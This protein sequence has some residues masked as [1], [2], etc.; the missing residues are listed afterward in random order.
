MCPST[1]NVISRPRKNGST[2]TI[3]STTIIRAQPIIGTGLVV[4]ARTLVIMAVTKSTSSRSSKS[5]NETADE[6]KKNEGQGRADQVT[7][8]EKKQPLG[9]GQYC[10]NELLECGKGCMQAEKERH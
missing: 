8:E 10:R 7:R 3:S 1:G 6:R 5:G 9:G 2:D 4:T